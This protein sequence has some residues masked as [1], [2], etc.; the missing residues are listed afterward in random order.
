MYTC[1]V[2]V[3]VD[4]PKVSEDLWQLFK[5]NLIFDRKRKI[6]ALNTLDKQFSQLR[7]WILTSVL[8]AK[9]LSCCFHLR[10]KKYSKKERKEYIH[11]KLTKVHHNSFSLNCLLISRIIQQYVSA[12]NTTVLSICTCVL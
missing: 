7:L 6:I 3:C 8:L 2:R 12:Y 5:K 1:L 4:C 10:L 9:Y 11:D